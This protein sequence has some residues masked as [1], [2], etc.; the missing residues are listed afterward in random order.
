MTSRPCNALPCTATQ[1]GREPASGLPSSRPTE[2]GSRTA[3]RDSGSSH[4]PSLRQR[5][6]K[7]MRRQI[8]DRFAPI[9]TNII[10]RENYTKEFAISIR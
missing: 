4:E 5:L 8:A 9:D 6:I 1:C 7:V 10:I 2:S 3:L